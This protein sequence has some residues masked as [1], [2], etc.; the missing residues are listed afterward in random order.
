MGDNT[1]GPRSFTVLHDSAT[2]R[3]RTSHQKGTVDSM[4]KVRSFLK[5]DPHRLG[6]PF[7]IET[8]NKAGTVVQKIRS[9]IHRS[10]LLY[11]NSSL[12]TAT[13]HIM[14]QNISSI[15]DIASTALFTRQAEQNGE[16]FSTHVLPSPI[17]INK[18][19]LATHR[20]WSAFVPITELTGQCT[21]G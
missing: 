13:N 9:S 16:P 4:S 5:E 19:A 21:V 17:V 18:K 11:H 7:K 2:L 1:S 12:T 15:Q 14:L 8:K 6:Q 10:L 3:A 20:S